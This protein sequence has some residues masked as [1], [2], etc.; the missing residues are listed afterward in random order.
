MRLMKNNPQK[1]S[2][3]EPI[4]ILTAL[5]IVIFVFI[6]PTR[7]L[8]PTKSIFSLSGDSYNQN[9]EIKT[10]SNGKPNPTKN[11]TYSNSISLSRGNASN[12]IQPYEEY[13]SI[14]NRGDTSVDIT[15]WKLK[16]AKNERPYSVSGSL[17]Y[18][19]ADEVII[20]RASIFISPSG[21]I[22]QQN[23][24][25]KKNEKA[26]I[27]T[28]SN[29]VRT[30][31]AIVNFKENK[32][33]GYLEDLPEYSFTPQLSMNCARPSNEP[34]A[35]SLEVSCQKYLDSMRSCHTPKFETTDRQGNVC[36]NCV[37]GNST[38]GS[39]CVAFIKSH[40]S[41]SGCI[42]NH[43]NDSDFS[44]NTWRVFLG[45]TWE[46]WAK[47]HETISLFDSSGNLVDYESY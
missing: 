31:Y 37:D 4:L 47:D 2:L 13:I 17:Q 27:T 16:N 25:L 30:P 23:I 43:Q 14:E 22:A 26:I 33:S 42:A 15:G 38:L 3:I 39:S 36:S 41:Y 7:Q 34:G 21:N 9:S 29:G 19:P 45:R 28:G 35:Q 44:L 6:M 32:C 1:G 8:G 10:N 20:P 18:F 5:C 40:F 24:V 11:S 46:L 12:S